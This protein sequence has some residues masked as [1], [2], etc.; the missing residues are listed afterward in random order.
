MCVAALQNMLSAY[1]DID[2]MCGEYEG[3]RF[4]RRE[5]GIHD[6]HQHK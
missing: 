3:D 2:G 1:V 4:M 5:Y 6:I